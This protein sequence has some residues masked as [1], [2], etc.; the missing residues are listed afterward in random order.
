[1]PSHTDTATASIR[2]EQPLRTVRPQ[3]SPGPGPAGDPR[4]RPETPPDTSTRGHQPAASTQANPE[5]HLHHSSPVQP[6]E[7]PTHAPSDGPPTQTFSP[8]PTDATSA[9]PERPPGTMRP[10]PHIPTGSR[11]PQAPAT[12]STLAPGHHPTAPAQAE[13]APQQRHD[14]PAG[15]AARPTETPSGSHPAP[16]PDP[17]PDPT[18]AIVPA[19]APRANAP[20]RELPTGVPHPEG[21]T[22]GWL[23]MAA[24]DRSCPW[25]LLL[26]STDPCS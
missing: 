1:M 22:P 20:G 25:L 21:G 9:R 23:E 16:S 4:P 11:S 7:G 24:P 8:T 19:D 5:P 17:D 3:T 12:P 6:T 15:P 13:P 18:H 2:P 26:R 14:P 10:Y